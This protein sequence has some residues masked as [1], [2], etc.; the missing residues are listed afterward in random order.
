MQKDYNY[1]TL[2][3]FELFSVYYFRMRNVVK[4]KFFYIKMLINLHSKFF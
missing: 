3:S 4:L 1:K 2:L